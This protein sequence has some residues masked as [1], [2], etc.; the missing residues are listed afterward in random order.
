MASPPYDCFVIS[1]IGQAE[2]EGRRRTTEVIEQYIKPAC[3]GAKLTPYFVHEMQAGSIP[4]H[5]TRALQTMPLAIAYLGDGPPWNANVMIEV[6]YRLGTGLPIVFLGGPSA[7]S[8]SEPLPF[9]LFDQHVIDLPGTNGPKE[10]E[11][12]IVTIVQGLRQAAGLHHGWIP[13]HASATIVIALGG[14]T[15]Q[16]LFTE[17]SPQAERLFGLEDR[18]GMT[19]FAPR[20]SSPMWSDDEIKSMQRLSELVAEVLNSDW[21]PKNWQP[22]WERR[23][24]DSLHHYG[25]RAVG[26]ANWLDD[27]KIQWFRER[28]YLAASYC[29]D[30]IIAPVVQVDPPD[31]CYHITPASN[32]RSILDRGL[33]CGADADRSTTGRTDAARRLHLTFDIDEAVK[34]AGDKLLGQRNPTQEWALFEIDSQGIRGQALRDPS[35]QTGFIVEA[36]AV[37]PESLKKIRHLCPR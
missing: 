24:W 15:D 23:I 9:D 10:R 19:V 14:E 12:M 5:I 34:W 3:E 4:Q 26:L 16:H 37:L 36:G 13:L 18:V 22:S 17:A 7:K 29:D 30:V 8:Q 20:G 2:T 6:G 35:S 32:E 33:L 27:G 25:V 28:D 11:T 31:K 1:P 21:C